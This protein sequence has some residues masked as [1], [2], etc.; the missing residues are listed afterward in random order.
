[1]KGIQLAQRFRPLR[2]LYRAWWERRYGVFRDDIFLVSYPRSGNTWV[3]FMLLQARPDFAEADFA[4]I[5]EIIPDMHGEEPWFQCRRTRV[6]KSHLTHWQPF[7]RVIYLARDGRPA[8][9][10]NWRYQKAEGTYAGSF[11]DFVTK[12]HWPSSWSAHVEGWMQAPATKLIVRYED[13]IADPATQ[14]RKMIDVIGWDL[15]D[16]RVSAI[17]ANSTKERMRQLEQSEG[18]ALHRVGDNKANW[19]EAFE[20]QLEDHFLSGMSATSKQLISS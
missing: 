3:R 6:I 17:V 10:S 4:R 5:Q 7:R 15:S 9:F 19:R 20:Q 16:Q 12:P 13:L 2:P 18:V 8:T 14:L 11:E 1:M